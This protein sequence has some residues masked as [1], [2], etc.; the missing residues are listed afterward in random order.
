MTLVMY[1]SIDPLQFEG[2]SMDAAAGYVDGAWPTYSTLGDFVPPGTILLSI[3]VFGNQ[4]ECVDQ[5]PGNI[6]VGPAAQWVAEQIQ[7]GHYKPVVYTSASNMGNMLSAL[8]AKGVSR[9][10]VRLWS[11]HYTLE[12]HI[13]APNVCGYPEVDG[14]QWTDRAH[15]R[16]LDQSTLIN[17]FF[18]ETQHGPVE[19]TGDLPMSDFLPD[20]KN[21]PLAFSKT[22]KYVR[23]FCN[24]GDVSLTITF[25]PQGRNGPNQTITTGPESGP[26]GVNIP[27]GCN[28]L[29]I[30][31]GDPPP[32]GYPLVSYGLQ[33]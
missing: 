7:T 2:L 17:D 30:R 5:E 1:D 32:G 9:S 16:N 26:N 22:V 15:G 19:T 18:L 25:A 12:D 21:I 28:A 20:A 13:C 23:F 29:I 6:E 14:T 33:S 27:D 24:S 11:A 3:T 10:E 4:A 8:N 31:R